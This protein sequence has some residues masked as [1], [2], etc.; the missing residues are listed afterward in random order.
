MIRGESGTGKSTFF[1]LLSNRLVHGQGK[2]VVPANEKLM[3]LPTNPTIL[4]G[5]TIRE[6]I[7][8][9]G[10]V[11]EEME[12]E[13]LK[14]LKWVGI[15]RTLDGSAKTLSTG[16]QKRLCC[17]RALIEQPDW[18]FLDETTA[19]LDPEIRCVIYDI[20]QK[21]LPKATL[22]FITHE[23]E[24]PPFKHRELRFFVDK[25]TKQFGYKSQELAES[26]QELGSCNAVWYC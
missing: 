2:V 18:L 26:K 19:N 8:Y 20:L 17:I 5:Q 7:A 25:D 22:V 12:A 9:P 6:A 4:E 15:N 14:Y 23:S 3:F 11:D 10:E 13:Y 24:P 16:E 1:K 21:H